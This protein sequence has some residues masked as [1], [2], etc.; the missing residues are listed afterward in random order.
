MTRTCL[1]CKQKFEKQALNRIVLV[2]KQVLFDSK[3]KIQA[4]GAYVCNSA[5]CLANFKKKRA[6]GRAFR[7]NFADE[8]YDQ[9][10]EQIKNGK[11][12]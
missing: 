6:L 11:S 8:Q 3:Q 2:E 10:I 12:I 4:R 7:Q 9:L 1:V 5:E